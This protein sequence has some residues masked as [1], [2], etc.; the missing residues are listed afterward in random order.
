MCASLVFDA[1]QKEICDKKIYLVVPYTRKYI[2]KLACPTKL[3]YDKSRLIEQYREYD[4]K[5]ALL[6]VSNNKITKTQLFDL[7]S[8]DRLL[9]LLKQHK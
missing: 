2:A 8:K 5:I 4:Y 9:S 6:T 3:I 7:D 1:A